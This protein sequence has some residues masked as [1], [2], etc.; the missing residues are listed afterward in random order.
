MDGRRQGAIGD[1]AAGSGPAAFRAALRRG[2]WLGWFV[3]VVT[4]AAVFALLH[5]P[6]ALVV[7]P[8]ALLF[9]LPA[10]LLQ[11]VAL[12]FA[13]WLAASRWRVALCLVGAHAAGLLAWTVLWANAGYGGSWQAFAKVLLLVEGPVAVLQVAIV[14]Q[15][16]RRARR[17][18]ANDPTI[19]P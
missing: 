15:H 8:L 18:P 3:A 14:L 1:E 19:V 4:V 6:G 9:G 5:S 7:A 12:V 2:I 16:L 11:E 17:A 10:A 13:G